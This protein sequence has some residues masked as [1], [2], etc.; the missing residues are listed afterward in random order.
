MYLLSWYQTQEVFLDKMGTG[1]YIGHS[2]WIHWVHR[3]IVIMCS[4]LTH[5]SC[6]QLLLTG[7]HRLWNN[8]GTPEVEGLFAEVQG[9]EWTTMA[10]KRNTKR[11]SKPGGRFNMVQC[12][13][14]I[15]PHMAKPM[16]LGLSQNQSFPYSKSRITRMR[17][18]CPL[19]ETTETWTCKVVPRYELV[20][21]IHCFDI[22]AFHILP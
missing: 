2:L 12:L 5:I 18:W 17:T 22:I 1:G 4:H 16:A 6:I 21:N 20:S 8:F 14:F 3:F 11:P 13:S 7:W 19:L 10:T 9:F 15:P